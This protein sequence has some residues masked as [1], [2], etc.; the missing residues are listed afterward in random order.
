[1]AKPELKTELMDWNGCAWVESVP[2]KLG[3]TPVLLRSRMPADGVLENFD[4]GLSAENIAEDFDQDLE[5]VRGALEFA[6][7]LHHRTAA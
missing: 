5:S 7:R 1:M 6:G 3:G 2:D 4:A